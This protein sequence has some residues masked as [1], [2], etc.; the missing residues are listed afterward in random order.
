MFNAPVVGA[1]HARDPIP[2]DRAHGA[3]LHPIA[4]MARSHRIAGMA[5][6]YKK[7]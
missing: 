1:G 5:R 2:T 4:G 6:S 3:L 7:C